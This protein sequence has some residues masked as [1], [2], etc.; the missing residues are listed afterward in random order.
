MSDLLHGKADKAQAK[1]LPPNQMTNLDW[2]KLKACADDKI[3]ASEK[4]KFVLEKAENIVGKGEN[5]G[6]QHFLLFPQCF[7]KPFLSGSFKVWIVWKKVKSSFA[8]T[9]ISMQPFVI[10][11]VICKAWKKEVFS[12]PRVVACLGTTTLH[13]AT[14]PARA[15]AFTWKIMKA[16]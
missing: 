5:A 15:G 6:Y 11:V 7:Q 9:K 2:S 14:A 10:F 16:D 1:T 13:G 12:G 4:L 8:L 3:N